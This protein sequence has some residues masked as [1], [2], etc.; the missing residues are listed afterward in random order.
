MRANYFDTGR[1]VFSY[2]T[3]ILERHDGLIIGNITY[4]SH[5][6]S[7]HQGKA[8]S[9]LADLRL[10]DVPQGTTDLLTLAIEREH[11]LGNKRNAEHANVA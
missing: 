4:Y 5:T 9:R 1:Q 10:D 11:I 7:R 3:C 6:T 2:Q 8:G